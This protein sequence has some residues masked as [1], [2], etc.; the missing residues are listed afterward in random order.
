MRHSI[1][2]RVFQYR[3][4]AGGVRWQQIASFLYR[5]YCV[6]YT[7]SL[8]RRCGCTESEDRRA[9]TS[10][11]SDTDANANDAKK[12]TASTATVT[13][14]TTPNDGWSPDESRQGTVSLRTYAAYVTAAGGVVAVVAV[15]IASIVAE[16]AKAFSFWWL[17]YWLEQGSGS[18]NV[19]LTD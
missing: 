7:G 4:Y 2:D 19:S 3:L 12:L 8:Q 9:S 17:A 18:Y 11:L 16:G 10:S 13:L 14:K 15:L 6:C 1:V 5:K